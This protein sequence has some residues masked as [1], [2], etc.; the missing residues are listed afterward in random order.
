[1]DVEIRGK[2]MYIPAIECKELYFFVGTVMIR[3][4]GTNGTKDLRT[5]I[6]MKC[7]SKPH[8]GTVF[9]S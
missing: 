1:M 3:C 4:H 5:Q 2:E 7:L 8:A 9:I 6:I